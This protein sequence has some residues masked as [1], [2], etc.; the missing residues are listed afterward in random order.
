MERIITMIEELTEKVDSVLEVKNENGEKLDSVQEKLDEI[1]D[2]PCEDKIDL[3]PVERKMDKLGRITIPVH[4]R[5]QVD[6]NDEM[7]VRVYTSG[8]RIIIEK[9]E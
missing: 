3:K 7:M 4:V 1:L 8:N 9:A 5:D 6:M 2:S